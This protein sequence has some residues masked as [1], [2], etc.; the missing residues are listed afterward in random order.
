[1]AIRFLNSQSIDGELTV[2]GN[3]GIGTTSPGEA[4]TVGDSTSTGNHI[5]VE[6]SPTDNTYTVFEGKRKYPKLTLTDTISGGSSFSLWNLGNTL[7]FGTNV[8]SSTNAA[9]YTKSGDAADVIFNGDVG[10]GTS[11]PSEKLHV[12]GNARVTGAYYDS[13]NLPGTSGQVLSSTATGTSWIDTGGLS[14]A[15][16]YIT[17]IG[18]VSTNLFINGTLSQHISP[19]DISF[20][21]SNGRFTFAKAAKYKLNF[22]LIVSAGT[23]T[24]V[25]V[26]IVRNS[27]TTLHTMN[28]R[29]H[30]AVDPVE[31]SAFMILE[32]SQNDYIEVISTTALTTNIGTSVTMV[33]LVT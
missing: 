14:Y 12:S 33:E 29:V 16:Y 28:F 6:G 3:V 11:S 23:S 31:R 4:L 8:G 26:T 21:S 5:L 30:S 1:M 10:L 25:T 32:F 20:S 24:T 13:N 22:G 9:W 27:T 18:S 19:V 2:T 15:S 7:R 17:A